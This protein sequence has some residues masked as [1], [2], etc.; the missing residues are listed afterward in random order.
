MGRYV[1]SGA[2]ALDASH[3]YYVLWAAT[4]GAQCSSRLNA[5]YSSSIFTYPVTG[6]AVHHEDFDVAPY[7][8]IDPGAGAV[9]DPPTLF[10]WQLR[11]LDLG[12]VPNDDM[13]LDIF[14]T[15][16]GSPD[17]ETW[18]PMGNV[19]TYT[20]DVDELPLAFSGINA[21]WRNFSYYDLGLDGAFG[22]TCYRTVKFNTVLGNG[23]TAPTRPS[24]SRTISAGKLGDMANNTLE[25]QVP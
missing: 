7:T 12:L 22:Y 11:N 4:S 13:T 17:Y 19:G 1:F 25:Y 3:S 15:A 20:I 9:V 10:N 5:Y 14:G 8:Q 23:G 24:S 2:P 6:T 16:T 18:P 21:G